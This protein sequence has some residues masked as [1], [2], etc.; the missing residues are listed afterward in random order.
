MT[1]IVSV[2]SDI[3]IELNQM[4]QRSSQPAGELGQLVVFGYVC[5]PLK[6]VEGDAQNCQH[7]CEITR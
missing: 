1:E 7:H 2:M 5:R 4:N 6:E 3:A